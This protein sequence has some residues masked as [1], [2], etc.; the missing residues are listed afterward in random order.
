MK[1]VLPD[2]ALEVEE[3]EGGR[4]GECLM[5]VEEEEEGQLLWDGT[6]ARTVVGSEGY[7]MC[8][9]WYR[10]NRGTRRDWGFKRAGA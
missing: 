10:S 1:R 3:E 4:H 9:R 2:L 8:V 5:M 7:N 6:R